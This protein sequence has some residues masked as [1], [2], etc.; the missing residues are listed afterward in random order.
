VFL[1]VFCELCLSEG[2]R[3]QIQYNPFLTPC[4]RAMRKLVIALPCIVDGSWVTSF[5]VFL[6]NVLHR[7]LSACLAH[8]LLQGYRQFDAGYLGLKLQTNRL[9]LTPIFRTIRLQQRDHSFKYSLFLTSVG[10]M[11]LHRNVLQEDN[12]M[13]EL[14]A[15]AFQSI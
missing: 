7:H 14:Y 11:A 1:L 12:I 6:H 8:L 4:R 13:C 5:F 9:V 10:I 3:R 2:I 15:D